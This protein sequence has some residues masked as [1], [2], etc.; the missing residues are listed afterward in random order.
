MT[1]KPEKKEPEIRYVPVQFI[2]GYAP[3][4]SNDEV[5]IDLMDIL[6]RI[7]DGRATIIKVTAVFA[8]LGILY[9]F[10]SPNVYTTTTKL[11]PEAQQTNSLGRLGGLAA[12]FGLGGA[13]GS[14]TN[15]LLPPQIFPE[16]LASFD[17]LHEIIK[18]KVYFEEVQDSITIQEFY[19]LYQKSNPLVEYT[20][21]LP[22]K[23]ITL[24]R[25]TPESSSAK[26]PSMESYNRI[27]PVDLA[28]IGS[29]RKSVEL[30]LEQQTGVQN[31]NVTTQYPEVTV[32]LAD[33]V[34]ESLS[35]Y[36]IRYR[37]QKSRQNLSFLEQRHFEAWENFERVQERLAKF[38]DQ[39]QGN[40][41]ASARTA[42]QNIQS[43]YNVKL[44]IYSSLTEQLEQARIKLQQD[45]P[46][47]NILQG[48]LYPN[49]K[50]GPNRR[51]FIVISTF[52]GFVFG[53]GTTL[54]RPL[55]YALK[56]KF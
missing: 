9:A 38:R 19:T 11:L 42:E 41:T 6:K 52:I 28:A 23:A 32:Q 12:Q 29:V 33:L 34:T 13:G 22:F 8:V 54:V 5:E 35:S 17:F 2:E 53:V 4:S 46:V 47:I 30:N 1:D 49:Q 55:I 45:T 44:N 36:L 14:A 10:G 16:I 37:T 24:L 20:I 27:H 26:N 21:G 50:S 56:N 3:Q 48:S 15:D 40:L 31:L 18:K 7:W 51:L 43:E 25:S 39:N